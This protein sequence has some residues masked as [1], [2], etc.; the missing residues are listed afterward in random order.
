[1]KENHN[2]RTFEKKVE[3]LALQ[4]NYINS[5]YTIFATQDKGKKK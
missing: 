1:V 5:S 2:V 3:L 4:T